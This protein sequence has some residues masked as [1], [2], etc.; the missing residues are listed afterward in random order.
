MI[1]M[2]DHNIIIQ[3]NVMLNAAATI[4]FF[5]KIESAYPHK[6]K[7]HIFCDNARYYRNKQV[8]EYLKRSKILLHFLPPYSPNLSPIERLWKWMKERVI[9][10]VYYD[11]YEDF[12]DAVMGF[13]LALNRLAPD[14]ELGRALRS[15]GRD[16]FR[17]LGAPV[18]TNF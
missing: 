2:I 13:F 10:N 4:K 17:P 11:A 9:Y 8:T 6:S 3:E 16:K 14:S 1:D 12:K 15:R 18:A 5:Q 7:I